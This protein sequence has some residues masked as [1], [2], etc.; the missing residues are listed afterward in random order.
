MVLPDRFGFGSDPQ[1]VCSR[2]RTG[3]PSTSGDSLTR[4]E[5][6]FS[7]Q[8]EATAADAAPALLPSVIEAQAQQLSEDTTRAFRR[9]APAQ[10]ALGDEC[11]AGETESTQ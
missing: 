3:L 8:P 4:R 5:G 7:S 11:D 2:C 6:Q 1:R 9:T 10:V